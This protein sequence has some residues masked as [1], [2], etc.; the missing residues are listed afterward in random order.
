MHTFITLS[1]IFLK[2]DGDSHINKKGNIIKNILFFDNKL[3]LQSSDMFVKSLNYQFCTLK[4]NEGKHNLQVD[5]MAL[6]LTPKKK[7]N[8]LT[9]PLKIPP[10]MPLTITLSI[11]FDG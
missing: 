8:F 1:N 6:N 9:D 2:K 4:I 5:V 7:V 10:Y 11:E 3:S